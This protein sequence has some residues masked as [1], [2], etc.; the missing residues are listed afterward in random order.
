MVTFTSQDHTFMA[1]ALQL[2]RVGCVLV[3]EGQVIGEGWHVKTGEAHAEINALADAEK[4]KVCVKNATAYVT[5]EPCFHTGRTPPCSQALVNAGVKRVVVAMLD[6][7]PLVASKVW[8]N[9]MR[10]VLKQIMVY[11]LQARQNSMLVLLSEWSKVYRMF[12]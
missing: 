2:A 12:Q 8:R 5:L 9:L 11:W 3:K 10:Q 4:A 6:P 1:R 7:N